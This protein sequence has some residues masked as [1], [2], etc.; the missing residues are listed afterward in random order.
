MRIMQT[1]EDV[2]SGAAER[3][4]RAPEAVTG[5]PAA[6]PHRAVFAGIGRADQP[7]HRSTLIAM[8]G[9]SGG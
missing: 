9:P 4:H 6:G 8:T 5:C 7:I 2:I 1:K 3:G